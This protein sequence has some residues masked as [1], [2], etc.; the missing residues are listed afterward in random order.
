MTEA[1]IKELRDWCESGSYDYPD[2]ELVVRLVEERRRLLDAL[3][4]QARLSD[5]EVAFAAI[6]FAEEEV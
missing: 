1:Q 3:S 6:R 5:E 2:S 4:G